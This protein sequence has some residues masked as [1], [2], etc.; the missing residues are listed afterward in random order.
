M[1][2]EDDDEF[3]SVDQGYLNEVPLEEE[4]KQMQKQMKNLKKEKKEKVIALHVQRVVTAL[5]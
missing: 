5:H 1:V 3:P 2:G 4:K